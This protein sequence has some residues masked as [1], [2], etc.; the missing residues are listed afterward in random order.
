MIQ[1]TQYWC[2]ICRFSLLTPYSLRSEVV[3]ERCVCRVCTGLV[4]AVLFVVFQ[5]NV[6][7]ADVLSVL[8]TCSEGIFKCPEDELPLD[9]AK[10]R[11]TQ[12]FCFVPRDEVFV[13]TFLVVTDT[14]HSENVLL[15]RK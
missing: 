9:Y 14:C 7:S 4:D 3:N 8:S 5:P 1:C 11:A 15:S 13:L 10:V 2:I 6:E 12:F